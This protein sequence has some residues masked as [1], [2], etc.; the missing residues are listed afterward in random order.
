MQKKVIY[1]ES[2]IDEGIKEEDFYN[3]NEIEVLLEDDEISPGEEAFMRGYLDYEDW[4]LMN[5]DCWH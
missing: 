4:D 3:D 2:E 1:L 5:V